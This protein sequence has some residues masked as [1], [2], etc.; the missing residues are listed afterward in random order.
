[1]LEKLNQYRQN[2]TLPLR[3]KPSQTQFRFEWV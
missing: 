2:L 3:Q 1:M